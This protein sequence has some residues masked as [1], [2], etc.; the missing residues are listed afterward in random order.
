[1][2]ELRL[3]LVPAVRSAGLPVAEAAR[4]YGVSRKTVFQ[5]LARSDAD[6]T[7]PLADRSRR[8]RASPGRTVEDV[9]HRVREARDRRSWGATP[10]P[11]LRR[12]GPAGADQRRD[13]GPPWPHPPGAGRAG[14]AAAAL[15]A[16]AVQRAVATRLQDEL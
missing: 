7:A 14:S 15:R 16:V 3:A 8:P 1:M 12:S 9:E 4:C 11:G 5:G 10:A 2:S 6:P 13:P